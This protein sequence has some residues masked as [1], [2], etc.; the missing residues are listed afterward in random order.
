[1][2]LKKY[3]VLIGIVLYIFVW[4]A[5]IQSRAYVKPAVEKARRGH[6]QTATDMRMKRK[7]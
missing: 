6:Q 4:S 7:R 1:M 3:Y 5:K 2:L